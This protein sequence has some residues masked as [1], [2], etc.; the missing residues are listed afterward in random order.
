[1]EA[2]YGLFENLPNRVVTGALRFVV[3]PWGRTFRAPR[4]YLGHAVCNLVLQPGPS[5]ERLTAGM[6]IS[7]DASDPVATLE[8]ALVAVIEAEPIEQKLR[9]ARKSATPASGLPEDDVAPAVAHGVISS[10]QAQIIE[11]ARALRRKAIMVDDFPK[12]LGKT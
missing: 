10:A 7:T 8:A 5:R 2:F 4:D 3:F 6:F 11:R 12:D 1:E 9:A